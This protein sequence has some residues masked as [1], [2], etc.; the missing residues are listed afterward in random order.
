MPNTAGNRQ[1]DAPTHSDWAELV[2][3]H[4]DQNARIRI[5]E[6]GYRHITEQVAELTV[7]L[8]AQ[9][10]RIE[11]NAQQ[12]AA[13]G[14]GLQANTKMTGEAL[15]MLKTV[16]DYVTTGTVLSR[17]GRWLAGLILTCSA[18]WLAIKDFL[19]IGGKP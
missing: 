11:E 18:L 8:H 14:T 19:T 16:Q 13:I 1:L 15:V 17:A 5:V 3:M 12:L 10:K 2:E 9:D 7:T 4:R 6:A